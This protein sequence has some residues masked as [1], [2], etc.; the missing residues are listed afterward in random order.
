MVLSADYMAVPEAQIR[1]IKADITLIG[2]KVV[3]ER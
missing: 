3:F 2:G 1:D